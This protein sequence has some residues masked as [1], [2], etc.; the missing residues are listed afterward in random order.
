MTELNPKQ[1][2]LLRMREILR[3]RSMQEKKGN[4]K[5]LREIEFTANERP[6]LAEP[7]AEVPRNKKDSEKPTNPSEAHRRRFDAMQD[8]ELEMAV[9]NAFAELGSNASR[10]AL[11]K[12][13][14]WMCTIANERGILNKICPPELPPWIKKL[15]EAIKAREIEGRLEEVLLL[16]NA[17]EIELVNAIRTGR[18]NEEKDKIKTKYALEGGNSALHRLMIKTLRDV[19]EERRFKQHRELRAIVRKLDEEQMAKIRKELDEKEIA[20]L[21]EIALGNEKD[22]GADVARAFHVT[23]ERIRQVERDLLKKLKVYVQETS[24]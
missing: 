8:D 1:A 23:R 15:G 24:E 16:L 5:K 18:Y 6:P 10:N 12:K 20:I 19:N 2:R 22:F 14:S 13:N 7:L 21:N 11:R 3:E 4:G 9:R 17:S